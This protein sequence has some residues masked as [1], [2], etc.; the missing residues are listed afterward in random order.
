MSHKPQIRFVK[1]IKKLSDKAIKVEEY[2][3]IKF[4][5]LYYDKQHFY[6]KDERDSYHKLPEYKESSEKFVLAKDAKE[7]FRHIYTDAFNHK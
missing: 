3:D 5:N 7:Y 4:D 6:G 1:G 2:D